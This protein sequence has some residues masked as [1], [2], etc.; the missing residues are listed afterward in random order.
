[1]SDTPEIDKSSPIRRFSDGAIQEQIDKSLAQL[2]EGASWAVI[3]YATRDEARLAFVGRLG[4]HLDW[5]VAADKPWAGGMDTLKV[6][7]AIRIYG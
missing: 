2:P 7:G 1:M 6:E 3:G 4:S 5:T